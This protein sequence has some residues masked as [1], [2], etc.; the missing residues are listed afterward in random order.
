MLPRERGLSTGLKDQQYL[1]IWPQKLRQKGIPDGA[2][3]LS[4]AEKWEGLKHVLG[5]EQNSFSEAQ[6]GNEG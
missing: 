5:T 1:K 2:K 4:K 3:N 6:G